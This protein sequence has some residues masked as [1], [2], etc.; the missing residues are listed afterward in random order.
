MG[1]RAGEVHLSREMSAP[2]HMEDQLRVVEVMQL[3]ACSSVAVTFGVMILKEGQVGVRSVLSLEVQYETEGADLGHGHVILH[4]FH[5][6][7]TVV[8]VCPCY[9]LC[10]SLQMET[11]GWQ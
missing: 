9:L 7:L 10:D 3:Q 8:I 6:H 2:V 4:H 11:I 1:L 5:H